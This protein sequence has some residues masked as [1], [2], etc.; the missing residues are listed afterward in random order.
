V[1]RDEALRRLRD[2]RVG[3]MATVDGRGSPHVVPFVFAVDGSTIY[4]AVDDKPKRS[5]ELKRLAN[6]AGHPWAEVVVDEYG[7]DWSALWWVRASGPARLVSGEEADRSK[8]LLRAKYTQYR[9][10]P[11]A[12]PFVAIDIEHLTWWSAT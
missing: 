7:E 6:L 3:R 11:P 10:L 9:D 2:A 8:E 5:R 12:G 4:W 1:D